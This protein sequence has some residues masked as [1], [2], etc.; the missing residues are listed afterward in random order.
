LLEPFAGAGADE[1]TVHVEPANRLRHSSGKSENWAKSRARHQ[2]ATAIARSSR[3]S[4]KLIV[5]VM[6]VNPGLAAGIH[7]RN[8]AQNQQAE[9]MAWAG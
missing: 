2:P 6:T 7:S 3:I 1:I 4:I 5:L 9:A 8:I